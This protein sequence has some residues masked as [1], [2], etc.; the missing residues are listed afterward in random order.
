[1]SNLVT[2]P[3]KNPSQS[4]NTTVNYMQTLQLTTSSKMQIFEF[5]IFNRNGVCLLHIDFQDESMNLKNKALLVNRDNE[6][7]YKL[8]FGLIFSMKSFVKVLSPVGGKDFFN[9]YS[10]SNYKLNYV[11]FLNGFRFVLLTSILKSDL[12]N[13]LKEIFN[14]YYVNLISKNILLNKDDVIKNDL[15]IESVNAYL[16][17]LNGNLNCFNAKIVWFT[18]EKNIFFF[19]V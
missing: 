18:L 13:Y 11:E 9:S 7:R 3:N 16:S 14:V 17:N 1:M 5:L 4:I 15:F 6:N 8:I 12:S 19:L 2:D 10:T